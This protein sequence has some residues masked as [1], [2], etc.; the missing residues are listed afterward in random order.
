LG[1]QSAPMPSG[2]LR[3]HTFHHS[4]IET[5]LV[6]VAFGERVHNTSEG[7]AVYQLNRLTASYL[8]CYFASNPDAAAQLFL[9]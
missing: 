2:V 4:L 5:S 9:P 6:P 7:E 3:S 1:Y 8:H